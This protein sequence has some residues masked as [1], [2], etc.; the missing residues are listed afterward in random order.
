MLPADKVVNIYA[1]AIPGKENRKN[2][3][4]KA[5]ILGIEGIDIETLRAL[6]EK[7]GVITYESNSFKKDCEY[8]NADLYEAG[9]CG[10]KDS[11]QKR[12]ALCEQHEL[13]KN[14]TPNALLE[15]INI[16]GI[17]I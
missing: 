5:G 3:P 9:L 6:F 8:T 1:P 17:N 15:A 13:P 7:S 10:K 12:N 4:S 11:A 2:Q 14:M 16:L